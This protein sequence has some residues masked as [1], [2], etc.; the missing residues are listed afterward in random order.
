VWQRP[1]EL[2]RDPVMFGDR[3]QPSDVIQGHLGDCY[4]V[5]ALSLL[6]SRP[7]M[8]ERLCVSKAINSSMPLKF[9]VFKYGEWV[10]V[11]V[12]ELIPCTQH[13]SVY[14]PAFAHHA[15]SSVMWPCLLEKAI[16]KYYKSY[17][18]LMG[19]NV[20]EALVDLTGCATED[21]SLDRPE[22]KMSIVDGSLFKRL[23]SLLVNERAHYLV[24]CASAIPKDAKQGKANQGI[25]TNHAYSILGTTRDLGLELVLL[26]NPQ[27]K[28]EWEGKYSRSDKVWTQSTPKVML[29][30]LLI[31][32][33]ALHLPACQS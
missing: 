11:H 23:E 27:G 25:I 4:V 12:D 9:R 18:A 16:A 24:G 17:G 1:V 13:G 32:L 33:L 21:L 10:T 20:A 15:N 30:L 2:S 14:K 28:N 22:V 3:I 7:Y 5:A 29:I 6:A 31:L 8:I 26:R 19:G